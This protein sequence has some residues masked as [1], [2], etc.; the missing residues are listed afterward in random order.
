MYLIREQIKDFAIVRSEAADPAA[1]KQLFIEG[2]FLQSEIVNGNG[3]KYPKE[4]M[5]AAVS[6][7]IDEYVKPKRALG[8]LNHPDSPDVNPERACIKIVSLE[9]EG[10]NWIGKAQVL[11]TPLGQLVRNLIE[12]DVQLAVSSRGL[13]SVDMDGDVEVI[14][15]DFYICTAADVVHNPSAPDAFVNG[16]MEGR[17]WIYENGIFREAAIE[18]AKKKIKSAPANRLNEETIKAVRSLFDSIQF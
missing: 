5:D 8:E 18:A 15:D 14:S 3:R 9:P 4:I 7:Y 10:N 17:Q 13:A 1:P 12:D 6:R 16:I 11:S 2:I